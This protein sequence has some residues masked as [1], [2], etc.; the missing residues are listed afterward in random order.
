MKHKMTKI[1]T[2][3]N[4]NKPNLRN[5][6]LFI[7]ILVNSFNCQ[8]ISAKMHRLVFVPTNRGGLSLFY[9]G[10]KFRSAGSTTKGRFG[11]PTQRWKCDFAGC[12]SYVITTADR[13]FVRAQIDHQHE[14]KMSAAQ[15]QFNNS[16]K[17]KV[18]LNPLARF[19]ALYSITLQEFPP[20]TVL[21]PLSEIK[22]ALYDIRRAS[23]PR[24]PKTIAELKEQ[25][26]APWTL[27]RSGEQFV[28]FISLEMIVLFEH[29][30]FERLC[31]AE[32]IYMDGTFKI[33]PKLFRQFYTIHFK[34]DG[35]KY[36]AVFILMKNRQLPT[37]KVAFKFLATYAAQ[38]QLT[39]K[40]K[41][42]HS[43][44]EVA[45]LRLV[46]EMLPNSSING[47][48]FHYCQAVF[49]KIK[50]LGLQPF[51]TKS[52]N[53]KMFIR[54]LY[55]LSFL[56]PQQVETVYRQLLVV[57][58]QIFGFD[59]ADK[60]LAKFLRYYES[61][62]ISGSA[63]FPAR[64]W[65][66]YKQTDRTN[67]GT[68]GFHHGFASKFQRNH[69]SVYYFLFELKREHQKRDAELTN[70]QSTG[71]SS[72]V[73]RK[74]DREMN[75]EIFRLYDRLDNDQNHLQ[76]VLDITGLRYYRKA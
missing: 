15:Q 58:T 57:A 64:I 13:L 52:K 72:R 76:F 60:Q 38:H 9:Q 44:F 74:R 28:Q 12:N 50:K 56:P 71:A 20:G 67:N 41:I 4:V 43:D 69:P 62:W 40:P 59:L 47:C 25:L 5:S 3:H 61:T 34:F 63:L 17:A 75:T 36:P 26:E 6:L 70:Q 14:P 16:I 23:V 33:C 45:I 42:I 31:Q 1:T 29:R 18:K 2:N 30:F 48:F 65:S 39:F 24:T 66:N 54:C 10:A 37:Y 73:P 27:T 55:S 46:A 22:D 53:F 21:K 51:Y 35:V 68:E 32:E 11:A 8:L 49:R 19:E 7:G